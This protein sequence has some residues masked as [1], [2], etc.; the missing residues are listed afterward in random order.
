MADNSW[1]ERHRPPLK[2]KRMGKG[3]EVTS[4]EIKRMQKLRNQ[5]KTIEEIAWA[6]NRSYVTVTRHTQPK[7]K[8]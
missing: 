7:G 5:G 4:E 6:V 1:Q 8:Q 3:N 2:N